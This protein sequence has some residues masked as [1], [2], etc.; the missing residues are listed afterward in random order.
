MLTSMSMTTSSELVKTSF[1]SYFLLV[2]AENEFRQYSCA[3]LKLDNLDLPIYMQI[4]QLNRHMAT[5]WAT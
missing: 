1:F 5:D 4:L 3:H 2:I